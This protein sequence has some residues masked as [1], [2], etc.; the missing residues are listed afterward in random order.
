[1]KDRMV[2]GRLARASRAIAL[3]AACS[4]VGACGA[5]KSVAIKNVAS[6]LAAPGDT[7]TSDNDPE[8]IRRAIPFALKLYESLLVSVPKH[9][10]LLL[11]TCSGYT[12]YSYA[13]VETDAELLREEEHHDQIKAL[14]DEAVLLY[15]RGK[16]YCVRA[17]ELKYPGMSKALLADPAAALKRVKDKEDVPLL[18]WTA[19]SWGAAMSLRKDPELVIDF[20]VVR[21]LAERALELDDTWGDASVHEMMITLDAQGEALGGSEAGARRH[22]ERAVSV[23]QGTMAGPY[24][25]LAEGVTVPKGDRGEFEKLIQQALAVDPE[26]KKP[27]RLVNIIAQKRAR[28]LL[29]RVDELFP[30]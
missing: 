15:L 28:A 30:K 1:M 12:S 20:P 17:L 21:A 23:Q 25:A 10:P 9:E 18:Y 4:A 24:V 26:K 5:L 7:I 6:T 2:A 19:A 8:L 14:R 13:F 11:A 22:F 3:T 27:V 29:D 16:D